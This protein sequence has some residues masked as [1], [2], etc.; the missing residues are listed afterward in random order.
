M[1]VDP[2]QPI[3]FQMECVLCE[4]GKVILAD[5]SCTPLPQLINE[6]SAFKKFCQSLDPNKCFIAAIIPDDTDNDVFFKAREVAN[7]I[8]LH[9]QALVDT[10]ENH[11]K[12][13]RYYK[14]SKRFVKNEENKP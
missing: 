6:H 10:P 8:G 5:D 1:K 11:R 14:E 3:E 2:N 9:M 13:W 12:Q 7:E 4:G